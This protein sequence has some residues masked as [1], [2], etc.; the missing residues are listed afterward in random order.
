MSKLYRMTI[1][2]LKEEKIELVNEYFYW[3]GRSDCTEDI[4]DDINKE[5]ELLES[6]MERKCEKR[7]G[8]KE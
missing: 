3:L 1:E 5:I 4:L 8:Y 7:I 2:E 6:F